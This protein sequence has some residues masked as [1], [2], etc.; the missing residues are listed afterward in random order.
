[1]KIRSACKDDLNKINQTIEL[2]VMTWQLPER[3]KR[4]AL[5][6][7]RYNEVDLGHYDIVV[8]EADNRIIGV[9]AWDT[10][11]HQGPANILSLLLHG[12]YVHPEYQ[13][14]SVGRKLF[15]AAEEAARG[16]KRNGILVKAQI[17]AEGFYQSQGLSKL[18]TQDIER[19]YAVQYWKP[20][21]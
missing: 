15:N 19:D 7:Y 4:L 10:E 3:V 21:G 18:E 11:P 20:L 8:A 14:Q 16:K 6:S 2:A 1:M 13:R 12:I 17:E 9:V 5:P